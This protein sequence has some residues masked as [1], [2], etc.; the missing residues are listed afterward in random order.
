MQLLLHLARA[1]L[2]AVSAERA[3]VPDFSDGEKDVGPITTP[4]SCELCGDFV[5]REA[6]WKPGSHYTILRLFSHRFC[7]SMTSAYLLPCSLGMLVFKQHSCEQIMGGNRVHSV[8]G[9]VQLNNP[10]VM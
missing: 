3:S 1:L 2:F 8:E 9:V 5:F 6:L 7:S 4:I 10:C